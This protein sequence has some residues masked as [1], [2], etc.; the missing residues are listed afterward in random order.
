MASSDDDDD[1]NNEVIIIIIINSKWVETQLVPV[2]I[3]HITY[4]RT[5]KVD[6]FR[7]SFRGLHW[8]PVVVIWKGKT[9]TILA[10]ALGSRRTKKNL[11]RDDRSQDLPVNDL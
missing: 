2:V 4:V 6:Y 7:F 8:K 5:M 11:C 9:G 3:S 1:D 10:F